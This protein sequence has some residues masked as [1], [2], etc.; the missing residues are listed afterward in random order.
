MLKGS[1][2]QQ[3][4]SASKDT[5][6]RLRVLGSQSIPSAHLEIKSLLA[7]GAQLQSARAPQPPSPPLPTAAALK[8]A[9]GDTLLNGQ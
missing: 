4:H 6:L 8:Y 3:T 2:T 9:K 7:K 1:G 5:V